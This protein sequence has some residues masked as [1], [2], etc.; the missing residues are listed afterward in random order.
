[1]KAF[2]SHNSQDKPFV[3]RLA[4]TLETH[5]IQSWVDEAELHY[6][7]CLIHKIADA[8]DG[9]D[10]VVAI[11]SPNSIDS[12]WV[13]KE[14]SLAM[15]KEITLG[16]VIVIPVLIGS[17]DIPFFL[18]DK[19]YADFTEP[20][21]FDENAEK[22][23]RSIRHHAESD[24]VQPFSETAGASIIPSH[25]ASFMG[26]LSSILAIALTLLIAIATWVAGR[27]H[28]AWP[29]FDTIQDDIF[30]FCTFMVA[31]Q[32]VEMIEEALKRSV[33]RTDPNF[34]NDLGNIVISGFHSKRYGKV[35]RKYWRNDLV[36]VALLCETASF[37]CIPPMFLYA[38]QIAIGISGKP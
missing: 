13:Q 14:L 37:L 38:T 36:K 3:R 12:A 9:L 15:T 18:R 11:I 7:D 21:A 31:M 2:I 4:T 19:L 25:K 29:G 16:K 8:I 1:M 6:G 23:A 20:D 24:Q 10:A 28:L 32:V 26:Y 22:L 17:C 35:M 5:G 34:A 33:M 30:V 27:S